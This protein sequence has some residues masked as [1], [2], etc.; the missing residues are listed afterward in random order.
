MAASSLSKVVCVPRWSR[1]VG[2]VRPN[3]CGVRAGF[4][5][6]PND[7]GW[8]ASL[9]SVVAWGSQT[10][11]ARRPIGAADAGSAD[12]SQ[13]SARLP[14]VTK[15]RTSDDKS[16]IKAVKRSSGGRITIPQRGD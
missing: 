16:G 13:S 7:F 10:G 1:A 8:R 3:S 2:S 11:P 9:R 4:S 12:T 6:P 14:A 5:G 15:V